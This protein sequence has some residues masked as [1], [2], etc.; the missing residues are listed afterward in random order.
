MLR[1][2]IFKCFLLASTAW[3]AGAAC[4]AW[5]CW[6]RSSS[7]PAPSLSAPTQAHARP[8]SR[9]TESASCKAQNVY[10]KYTY[11]EMKL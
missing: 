4:A 3:G 8:V 10:K 6:I 2:E 9:L 5:N 7:S 11:E 1:L